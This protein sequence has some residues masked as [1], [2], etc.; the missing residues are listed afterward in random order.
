MWTKDITDIGNETASHKAL[1]LRNH[2]YSMDRICFLFCYP[3]HPSNPLAFYF[4]RISST[5]IR[6]DYSIQYTF[7][8]TS[9]P[10]HVHFLWRELDSILRSLDFRGATLLPPHTFS[11][12]F[13]ARY[14]KR[15]E[16]RSSAYASSTTAGQLLSLI[17]TSDMTYFI[18][19]LLYDAVSSSKYTE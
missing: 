7:N 6:P 15:T 17:L 4:K 18:Y 14:L 2:I 10:G 13:E 19:G 12:P 9:K 16:M 1:S 11:R 8:V 5:Q 3:S